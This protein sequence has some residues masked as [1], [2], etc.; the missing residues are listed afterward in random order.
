MPKTLSSKDFHLDYFVL[1]GRNNSPF[2]KYQICKQSFTHR[3]LTSK[4]VIRS[5]MFE[6]DFIYGPPK[7]SKNLW[8]KQ[9]IYHQGRYIS[10]IKEPFRPAMIGRRSALAFVRHVPHASSSILDPTSTAQV[11]IVTKIFRKKVLLCKV[12]V[13]L[14]D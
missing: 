2:E 8:I 11:I 14:R 12:A 5:G 3:I 10:K 9:K 4:A 13:V 6:L 7:S 1:R